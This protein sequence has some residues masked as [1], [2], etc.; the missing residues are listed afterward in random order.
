M[1]LLDA[2]AR[3]QIL[4]ILTESLDR[5]EPELRDLTREAIAAEVD[6]MAERLAL[7]GLAAWRRPDGIGEPKGT[8]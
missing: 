2:H 4:A 6:R 5:C 1:T 3:H 7:Q 8:A